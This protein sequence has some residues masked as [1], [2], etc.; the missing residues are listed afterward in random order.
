M[1]KCPKCGGETKLVPAGVSK[2]TGKEYNAFIGCKNRE[3]DYTSNLPKTP[4]QGAS[5]VSTG[6]SPSETVT[7]L[8]EISE[9]LKFILD[10]LNERAG[11]N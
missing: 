11:H 7:L 2:K 5:Q 9:T 4:Q 3:C 1:E 6:A 8:R 10:S